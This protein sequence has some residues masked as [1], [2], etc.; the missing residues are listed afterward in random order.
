[1]LNAE[2]NEPTTAAA[3]ALA[4][5]DAGSNTSA[6]EA[7]ANRAETADPAQRVFERV[8]WAE[9]AFRL[10]DLTNALSELD[11][12]EAEA[13][14]LE[15][16]L[17]SAKVRTAAADILVGR[18]RT[19]E[20]L[21]SALEAM[22]VI[23]EVEPDQAEDP[24][25]LISS[26]RR[27]IA[28]LM[29]ELGVP[30][31]AIDQL[32]QAVSGGSA[33]SLQAHNHLALGRAHLDLARRQHGVL[34]RRWER[35]ARMASDQAKMAAAWGK[36]LH[37]VQSSILLGGVALLH[38]DFDLAGRTL[39]GSL[40]DLAAIDD[41]AIIGRHNLN[42][43]RAMRGAG[44][45]EDAVSW[46]ERAR[47]ASRRRFVRGLATSI[48]HELAKA[49]RGLGNIELALSHLDKAIT[50]EAQRGTEHIGAL[51]THLVQQAELATAHRRLLRTSDELADQARLDRLTDVPNRLALS[52]YVAELAEADHGDVAALFVDVDN[53]KTVNDT[54]GHAAGDRVLRT[55]AEIVQHTI[56]N[57]DKVFRYGGD[58]FIVLLPGT[59]SVVAHEVA[60]RIRGSVE[61]SAV[62]T[63]GAPGEHPVTVSVGCCVGSGVSAASV[64]AGADAAVYLAKRSGRNRVGVASPR[65]PMTI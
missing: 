5:V 4:A 30:S 41:P 8:V 9:A 40:P 49:H 39:V 12:A 65:A 59:D 37:R 60:E 10:G 20:A 61:Q 31:R 44:H 58:E 19:T 42:L 57:D 1:M 23:D 63:S 6:V 17:L 22:V 62:Q 14:T 3:A 15:A 35:S 26:I 32:R 7:L 16:P 56:R 11:I 34:D 33:S 43:A 47:D 18:G 45:H 64:I 25:D 28:V 51:V 46:L 38:G 2:S 53:F 24:R 29:L 50:L 27:D 36:A 52:L 13:S 21:T 55:V 54:G 48:E